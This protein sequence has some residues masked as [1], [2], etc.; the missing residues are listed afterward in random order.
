[1]TWRE[2]SSMGRRTGRVV[3]EQGSTGDRA[4]TI[5][6]TVAEVA[7][8]ERVC[9]VGSGFHFMSGI[10]T[11]TC[12]LSN[13]FAQDY[14]T[15]TILMRRLIPRRLYPGRARVGAPLTSMRYDPRV[16]VYDGVDY[17]WVPSIAGAIRLLLRRRPTVIVF[18][19]WSGTVVH[20]FLLLALIGRLLGARIVVE[21]HEVLDTSE[22]AFPAVRAYLKLVSRPFLGLVNAVIVHSTVDIDEVRSRF[23]VLR[24]KPLRVIA[25]GSSVT[26]TDTDRWA[27][28]HT[29][30][31]VFTLLYF[32][33]IRHYK[34]LENLIRAFDGLTDEQAQ[35]FHLTV[36]GETWQD[37]NLPAELIEVSPRR[38]RITFV[39]T[40]VD[41]EQ[42][43]GYFRA[44]DA[45]VLP[46]LRSSGS[47]PLHMAM[48]H[49]LPVAVS[50][51]GGLVEAVAGYT[52]ARLTRVGDV[53]DLRAALLELPNMPG[54][55]A[56]PHDW[57]S[58]THAMTELFAD[59]RR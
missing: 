34:G 13:A 2:V 8:T 7:A 14:P 38:D 52:G 43:A 45:V 18:Q 27:E 12:M 44:A 26:T 37:W 41:D 48:S 17:Y 10:S 9:V 23:P 4:D 15:S 49:G 5:A 36:V 47:G 57:A 30:S 3:S 46:Y 16:D 56:D 6:G 33:T 58:V 1:M 55:H 19:W 31:P 42:A 32:G 25:M 50:A 40:Y 22:F 51:V 11:H 53:A 54:P 59:A 20:T 24:D 21:F 39:N 28:E 29:P 35:R